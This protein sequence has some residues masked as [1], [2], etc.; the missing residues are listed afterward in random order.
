MDSYHDREILKA[1]DLCIKSSA[2][3][4]SNYHIEYIIHFY[5]LLLLG[6]KI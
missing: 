5:N 6:S 3:L 4:I 2:S 1:S